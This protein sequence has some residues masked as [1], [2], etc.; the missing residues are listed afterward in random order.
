MLSAKFASICDSMVDAFANRAREV[1]A[2][3]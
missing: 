2:G 1:Y 3:R